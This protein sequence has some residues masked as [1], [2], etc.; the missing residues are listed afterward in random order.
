MVIKGGGRR[1]VFL[2]LGFPLQ[3]QRCF[4]AKLGFKNAVAVQQQRRCSSDRRLVA[5]A[6]AVRGFAVSDL[7]VEG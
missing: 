2:C 6:A 1:G 3:L 5:A 7:G 4:G